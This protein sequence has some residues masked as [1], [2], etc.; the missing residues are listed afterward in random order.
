MKSGNIYGKGPRG[1]ATRLHALL[2][3]SRGACERCGSSDGSL[4]CAHIVSRRYASTRTDETNA[5]CLD[6][7]CHQRLT[8]HPNEHVAFAH[9]THGVEGY[10]ALLAKAYNAAGTKFGDAFWKAEVVRLTELLGREAA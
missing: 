6:F 4:Q 5:W 10:E 9:Q 7:R 8:E 1:K 2:V 3:R